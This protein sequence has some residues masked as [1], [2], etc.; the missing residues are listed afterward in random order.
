MNEQEIIDCLTSL[1]RIP[2]YRVSGAELK[3]DT[4]IVDLE[5]LRR[6]YTC[7]RCGRVVSA[8]YDH[9]IQELHYLMFWQYQTTLR[10][11]RYRVNCPKCGVQ[12]E[13]IEFADIR[14][15]NKKLSDIESGTKDHQRGK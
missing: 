1:L 3:C 8:A 9:T 14:R 15:A 13:A 10:F 2:G 5:R 11:P 4:V 7:G 6:D 12:T